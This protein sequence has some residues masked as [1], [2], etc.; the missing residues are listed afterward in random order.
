MGWNYL[1][2]PASIYRAS[3]AT[4]AAEVD[5]ERFSVLEARLVVRMIHA[6]GMTDLAGDVQFWGDAAE[7]GAEALALGKPIFVDV[8]ML[9][10]G[11]IQSRLSK[12][13]AVYCTTHDPRAVPKAAE[14]DNTR[15]AAGVDLWQADE[16]EGAVV[17]IGNA[18]TALFRLMELIEA[19]QLPKPACL[20]GLPVGFVGAVESKQALFEW[21]PRFGVPGLV[22]QGRRGGSAMAAAAVNALAA[23]NES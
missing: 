2:D 17:A 16:V 9:R 1:R 12:K 14:I 18:P 13:N 6:C 22:V 20:I 10:N 4:I 11:I 19:A 5:L 21:G 15:S 3:F 8:E 23:Q 7:K